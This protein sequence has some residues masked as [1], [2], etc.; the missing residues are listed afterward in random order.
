M[1]PWAYVLAVHLD[2]RKSS[3]SV[4]PTTRRR[5]ARPRLACH[6]PGVLFPGSELSLVC[7]GL[8]N[9]VALRS[10]PPTGTGLCAV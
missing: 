1:G 10:L 6:C 7:Y 8:G 9:S 2:K 5:G 4:T 3:T